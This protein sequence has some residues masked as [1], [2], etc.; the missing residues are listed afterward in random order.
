MA[1]EDEDEESKTEEPTAKRIED[2]I[3]KG[4]TV[5]SKELTN[6]MLISCLGIIV[7]WIM[8]QILYRLAGVLKN[9][10]ANIHDYEVSYSSMSELLP[11]ILNKVLSITYFPFILFI[12]TIIL[13]NIIQQGRVN[14]STNPIEPKLSKISLG[15]GFKR[16]FSLKSVMEFV[17]GIFKLA[18]V[19]SISYMTIMAEIDDLPTISYQS[20]YSI[21]FMLFGIIRDIFIGVCVILFFLGVFDYLY[22]RYEFYKSLRMTKHEVKE[23]QKQTEG[24]PEIKSKMKSIR[25]EK[26]KKR[27][28]DSVPNANVVINNPTHYSVALQYEEKTMNAPVVVAKGLDNIALR[29]REI[30]EEYD[31][32]QVEDPALARSL[33]NNVK[34]DQ[35]INVEHY[36][37]VAKIISYVF[38]LED[39]KKYWKSR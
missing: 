32:P 19:G 33:Y 28:M 27:M 26:A 13:S 29:M 37:A 21:M 15:S 24:N 38:S 25:Q 11:F 10:L 6:F 18:L 12:I 14:F 36:E 23:E 35:P 22:Q 30:A 7:I 20:T 17:K 2:A 39:K 34:L 3:E 1:D 8:P 16:I 4:Q 9:L 5:N 31:I